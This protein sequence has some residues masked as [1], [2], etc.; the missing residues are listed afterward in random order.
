MSGHPGKRARLAALAA[1]LGGRHT[2]Q[3]RIEFCLPAAHLDLSPLHRAAVLTLRHLVETGPI[4]LTPNYAMKRYFVTW[5]A[6]AFDWPGYRPEDLYAVNKVLNEHDFPP[7]Y[8]LHDLLLAGKLVR[9]RKGFLHITKFGKDLLAHPGSLWLALTQH[10]LTTS[11]VDWLSILNAINIA[12]SVTDR[13]FGGD[14]ALVY[15]HVLRPLAWLGLL[16]EEM[17]VFTKSPLWGAALSFEAG[18]PMTRH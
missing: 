1:A 2:G 7:L 10:M 14:P 6:E 17:R 15:V 9:R 11:E 18:T 3:M 16:Q 12:A 4:G 5:A 8:A 13:D